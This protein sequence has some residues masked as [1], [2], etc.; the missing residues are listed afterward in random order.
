M[1]PIAKGIVAIALVLVAGVTALTFTAFRRD[2]AEAH[3]RTEA[4]SDVVET[5]LGRVEYAIAGRGPTLLMVHGTGGGFDQALGF[6]E[7]LMQRG[8]RVVAP[9]RFGYLRSDFPEDPSSERQADAFAELL[10]HLGIERVAVAGGSAGA[11]AAVQ[12]A[13]RYPSRCSALVLVVPAA[14]VRGTDPVRMTPMQEFLVRQMTS[15]D[16]LFWLGIQLRKDDMIGTLLATDP[17][18]V[19]HA[20]E[21]ERARVERILNE[22]LPVSLRS[23][24]MLNDARLAGHPAR[25]DFTRIEVP[26]LVISVED[27]RFGTAATARDIAAAVPRSRLVIYPSGGHVWVGHDD[28]LWAEVSRFLGP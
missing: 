21:A 15:S 14:N 8:F 1:R 9:S 2:I 26:T 27:D 17:A 23:R 12:F 11:L 13:L 20:P 28:R 24:G 19:R 4:R 5:S 22:I 16:L 7:R 10:D 6:T 18:L 3:R 25:V